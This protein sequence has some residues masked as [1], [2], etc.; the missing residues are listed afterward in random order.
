[1]VALLVCMRRLTVQFFVV[2][3]RSQWSCLSH[4]QSI[5]K[6]WELSPPKVS[7]CMDHLVQV[8]ASIQH[9]PYQTFSF[10]HEHF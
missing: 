10:Y 1:M 5:M 2:F 3:C 8:R 6:K 9:L 4:I 7:S